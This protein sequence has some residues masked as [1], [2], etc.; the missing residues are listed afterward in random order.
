MKKSILKILI[1]LFSFTA[2]SQVQQYV[3]KHYSRVE[4]K[5]VSE[6]ATISGTTKI[7]V[8]DSDEIKFIEVVDLPTS[9]GGTASGGSSSYVF[10]AVDATAQVISA[11]TENIAF[12]ETS[13]VNNNWNGD[14]YTLSEDA[15]LVIFGSIIFTSNVLTNLDL[16]VNGIK[17]TRN[18]GGTGAS[19]RIN[20]FY[21]RGKFLKDDIISIRSTSTR[22]VLSSDGNHLDIITVS[23]G[24]SGDLISTNNLS[25]VANTSTARTNLDVYSKSESDALVSTGNPG[26]FIPTNQAD[27]TNPANAGLTALITTNIT[28][29]S[30]F[31]FAEGLTLINNGGFINTGGFTITPNNTYIPEQGNKVVINAFTGTLNVGSWIVES[32]QFVNFGADDTNSVSTDNK[33]CLVNF[34]NVINSST[35]KHGFINKEYYVSVTV[36]ISL[37]FFPSTVPSSPYIGLGYDNV[38]YDG[39]GTLK[40]IPNNIEKWWLVSP[41]NTKNSEFNVNIRG[42][43]DAHLYDI[44]YFVN[45]AATT[46]T[47]V[48]LR[49]LE[50]DDDVDNIIT[51]TIDENISI[52]TG[53]LATLK[54]E[55][56]NHINTDP[57][58]SDYTAT[59][60]S[61]NEFAIRGQA[62]QYFRVFL[63]AGDTNL[64]DSFGAELYA[65]LNTHEDGY[66]ISVG[67]KADYFKIKNA[68]LSHATGE[69]LIGDWQSNGKGGI[70]GFTR[71]DVDFNTGA[72]STNASGNWA[73]QTTIRNLSTYEHPW[74]Y[75]GMNAYAA[76]NTLYTSFRVIW[77]DASNQIIEVSPDV[78]MFRR[79]NFR[80]E[81][82]GM[83]LVF[84]YTPNYTNFNVFADPKSIPLGGEFTNNTVEYCRRQAISNPPPDLHILRNFFYRIGGALPQFIIDWEDHAKYSVDGIFAFN[85]IKNAG[86]GTLI[87]KGNSGTQVFGNTYLKPNDPK[88]ST[89][90]VA[91]AWSRDVDIHND[92]YYGYSNTIDIGTKFTEN[93]MEDA[94]MTIAAGGAVASSNTYINVTF[95]DG[96]RTGATTDA[97][98]ATTSFVKNNKIVITKNWTGRIIEEFGRIGW[99]GNTWSFNDKAEFHYTDNLTFPIVK[100][101]GSIVGSTSRAQKTIVDD[102]T[103]KGFYKNETITGLV[104]E[105]SELHN[106]GWELYA[107]PIDGFTTSTSLKIVNGYVEPKKYFNNINTNGWLEL[108]LN[109]Y[110][111]SNAEGDYPDIYLTNSK[112]I[113]PVEIDPNEG[114]LN[115]TQYGGNEWNTIFSTPL[116]DVNIYVY[117]TTFQSLGEVV[118][119]YFLLRQYG[120]I[121]FDGCSFL[122]DSSSPEVIDFTDLN[123]VPSTTGKIT[124]R[125]IKQLSSNI[126]FIAR[127]VDNIDAVVG[128]SSSGGSATTN[129]SDLTSG[130]LANGRVQESNVTQHE[131]ALTILSNQI[132]TA[133]ST[134]STIDMSGKTQNNFGAAS[135][136]TTFIM[137]NIAVGGYGEVL[138]NGT[139]E[140]VI[141]GAVK[142]PNTASW[143]TA[144]DMILCVK[145]FNGTRKFWF[146][147]F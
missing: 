77:Y 12:T 112:I 73:Y 65:I 100:L 46:G 33:N 72:I 121:V 89:I 35:G 36:P 102:G 144:T 8:I 14:T 131:S 87:M 108:E 30:D 52:T 81:Y 75:I 68:T 24:G 133:T 128:G 19:A 147:K 116:K 126:S 140:P 94:K 54:T 141:T 40:V 127:P 3:H 41:Y 80:P 29:T 71:G 101:T 48:N 39:I 28:A 105:D 47:I 2:T 17:H 37:P 118:G 38:V 78:D 49:L 13:D 57:D 45:T 34:F 114:Y 31:T 32:G 53:N 142:L 119:Y 66:L 91:S 125:N 58:F 107:Q 134:G 99:E 146:V 110:T 136:A 5:A 59:L 26:E 4:I 129:A 111:G 122:S 1:L 84:N 42:D 51:K 7:L 83:R 79:I 103:R 85:T 109:Q 16:Y 27:L 74:M 104:A 56:L 145:D 96:E 23:S 64:D 135:S 43:R 9:G 10:K 70:T 62:G 82:K 93:H 63:T 98:Q 123:R 138:V 86:S 115:N 20:H 92:K 88:Y 6:L 61:G 117:N 11:N 130:I 120:E 139:T 95:Q 55:I 143:I 106:M 21:Y 97:P 50:I 69:S 15:E 44:Q 124:I 90:G 25:D 18:I 67:S 132:T 22:T 60:T 113:V 76:V 137:S